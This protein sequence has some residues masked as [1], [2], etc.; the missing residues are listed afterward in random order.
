M[1]AVYKIRHFPLS[2]S[3]TAFNWFTSLASNSINTRANLEERFHEYFYNGETKLKLSDLTAVRKEYSETVAGY[4]KWFRDTR[5]KCYSRT[6]RERD[7]ADLALAR[8]S[9]YLREK[10]KGHEFNDVN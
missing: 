9:S 6:V 8:L 5:N 10:L 7:I 3:G 4:I 1:N 2:L